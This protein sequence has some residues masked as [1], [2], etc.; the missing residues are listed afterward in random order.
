MIKLNFVAILTHVSSLLATNSSKALT[1]VMRRALQRKG[2]ILAFTCFDFKNSF[3]AICTKVA[4]SQSLS[5][6][7][8]AEKSSLCDDSKP[9]KR[10]IYK[11]SL[12][13]S[14]VENKKVEKRHRLTFKSLFCAGFRPCIGRKSI[15]AC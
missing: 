15:Q 5:L 13:N 8:R 3:F 4:K 7:C 10:L 1:D 2:D 11:E 6:K 9:R 12:A 14:Y